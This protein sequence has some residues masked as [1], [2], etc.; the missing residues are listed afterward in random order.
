MVPQSQVFVFDEKLGHSHWVDYLSR[1]R[2]LDGLI[3]Q[4]RQGV[5][6]GTYLGYRLIHIYCE[7]IGIVDAPS[8]SEFAEPR[9]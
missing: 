5:R 9:L 1:A 8:K 4:L 2:T 3:K 6:S 7:R